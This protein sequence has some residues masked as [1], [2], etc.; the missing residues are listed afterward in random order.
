[1]CCNFCT[2]TLYLCTCL[3]VC[4]IRQIQQIDINCKSHKFS[5]EGVIWLRVPKLLHMTLYVYKT[6]NGHTFPRAME[7]AARPMRPPLRL[8]GCW[9]RANSEARIWMTC[10]IWV[11]LF[12]ATNSLTSLREETHTQISESKPKWERNTPNKCL[13]KEL[14]LL[15]NILQAS[16]SSSL[17]PHL[18][19]ILLNSGLVVTWWGSLIRN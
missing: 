11:E 19:R 17:K 7:Q 16:C 14:P 3:V 15:L 6:Y 9:D 5:V 1:M 18:V 13:R 4:P 10:L 2:T 8:C 12:W